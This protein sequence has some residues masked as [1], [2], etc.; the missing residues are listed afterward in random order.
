MFFKIGLCASSVICCWV[1]PAQKAEVVNLSKK[2][3][4]AWISLAIGD[5]A[6][7]VSMIMEA[8]IGVGIRG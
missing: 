3:G 7:D 6:N 5:G 8:N 4:R 2:Y 1:S